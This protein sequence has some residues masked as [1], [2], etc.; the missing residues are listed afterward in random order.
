M[1]T[2]DIQDWNVWV[3]TGVFEDNFEKIYQ[4][5]RP[6]MNFSRANTGI[7]SK[8]SLRPRIHL[9]M[10][11]HW[12]RE[13]PKFRQLGQKFGLS[14]ASARKDVLFLLPLL[15]EELHGE[16]AWPD[17]L[18]LGWE[19]TSGAIDGTAHPRSRVHP[20]QA[21]WYRRDKGF[22]MLGQVI[23]CI[24]GR[25]YQVDLLTGH[26]NDSGKSLQ[27]VF[28]FLTFKGALILTG[29]KQ[30]LLKHKIKLLADAGYSFCMLVTPDH[31][32]P[33]KWNNFQKGMRSV[34]ETTI[35]L[36]KFFAVTNDKFLG[37]P[38]LHT[39]AVH[40]CYQL[41]AMRL[42]EFPLRTLNVPQIEWRS[43]EEKLTFLLVKKLTSTC[44]QKKV[45]L[46]HVKIFNLATCT[47]KFPQ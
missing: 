11:L 27:I 18:P 20:R 40:V 29:M 7:V 39:M 2:G 33:R 13:H 45:N 46:F 24:D 12:L 43:S 10:V 32:S 14:A 3:E 35:G 41:T 9:L 1:H 15:Q 34:V 30:Y 17:S 5:L 37:S 42:K 16:I 21:D 38:E 31:G 28:S 4:Q 25:L 47:C 36:V 6:R 19:G 8:T 23:C 44:K 26:N 22:C